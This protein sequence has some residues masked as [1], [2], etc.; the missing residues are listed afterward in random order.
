MSGDPKDL[1]PKEEE[2]KEE[3]QDTNGANGDHAIE[4][5][6]DDDDIME[7]R[8]PHLTVSPHPSSSPL[9]LTPHPSPPPQVATANGDNKRR[10]E[11]GAG[12]SGVKRPRWAPG[13]VSQICL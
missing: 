10:A 3:V 12:P 11:E 13:F 6:A 4:V 1:Q 2:A 9:P 5:T 8:D 7:V